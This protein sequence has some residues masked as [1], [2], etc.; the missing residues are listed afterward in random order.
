MVNL[1]QIFIQFFPFCR[2]DAEIEGPEV[3]SHDREENLGPGIDRL[4]KFLSQHGHMILIIK[5][6]R[7]LLEHIPDGDPDVFQISACV[8]LEICDQGRIL[9]DQIGLLDQS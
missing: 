1:L 3:H 9:R 7:I 6:I 2:S 4:L 5:N 8:P